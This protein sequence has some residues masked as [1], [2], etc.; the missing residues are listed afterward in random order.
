M[1]EQ[2]K[3]VFDGND[4]LLASV[5]AEDDEAARG[6]A[7]EALLLDD[8][9]HVVRRVLLSSRK[10]VREE[11]FGDIAS[12]VNLRIVRRLRQLDREPIANFADYVATLTYNVIYDFLRS[13]Y[14]QRTRLK[15]RVRYGLKMDG[16][17]ALWESNGEA[18][19]G[20]SSWNGC[21][22]G[23]MAVETAD[24]PSVAVADPER[25]TKAIAAV[26]AHTGAPML[27]DDL[28]GL[29]GEMWNVTDGYEL[30][31]KDVATP[32]ASG[33]AAQYESRQYLARVWAEVSS[34]RK[35]Q[36]AALLLNLR[37]GDGRNA[38][39]LLLLARI[40]TAQ[41]IAEAIGIA[42]V[43]LTEIWND[44]PIDDL[45]IASMLGLTRQQVIN[46]R[47]SARERLTRRM[48]ERRKAINATRGRL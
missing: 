40:A 42:P 3:R 43:R 4:R 10:N 12:T 18:V 36:R 41:Q 6:E 26:F 19:A 29:L 24:V 25:T 1:V 30:A 39:A 2:A 27:L 48:N 32:E 44:L 21:E 34:L 31:G 23:T 38:L 9:R 5:V 37:D 47:K 13:R 22:P 35:P 33:P 8:A 15:N 14:P 20:L 28:V 45:R 17:F 11:D 16:R 7:I 46:L